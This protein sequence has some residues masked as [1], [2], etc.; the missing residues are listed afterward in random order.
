MRDKVQEPKSEGTYTVSTG[1]VFLFNLIVGAGA[2][3]VPHAFA[4]VSDAVS[5]DSLG[6][7][8][9][10]TYFARVPSRPVYSW[11]HSS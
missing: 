5:T 6:C 4:K 11:A 2:L 7:S 3:T 10:P 9:L 8:D 1:F